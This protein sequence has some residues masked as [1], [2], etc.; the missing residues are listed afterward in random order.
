[1]ADAEHLQT[2]APLCFLLPSHS[3]LFTALHS[4]KASVSIQEEQP[5]GSSLGTTPHYVGMSMSLRWLTALFLFLLVS[6]GGAA[7]VEDPEDELLNL[8]TDEDLDLHLYNTFDYD[9][10]DQEIDAPVPEVTAEPEAAEEEEEEEN[11]EEVEEEDQSHEEFP[12]PSTPISTTLDFKAK[13]LFGPNTG[14]GMPT[15]LLCVC[16]G[17]SVY[18]DD[19]DLEDIPPLPKD[20]AHFYGRFNKI[21][22]I[23]NSTFINLNN[24]QSIDLTGNDISEID[25]A[26]FRPLLLLQQLILADNDVKMLPELPNS[27]K[28]ID[29][30]NNKLKN[31][32]LHTEGFQDMSDLEYLYLSDNDLDYVP[33]P[34]P[35]SLRV[36][37]LQN[38]NIQSLHVDTFCH[39]HD[40]TFV[41]QKLEDI[42]LDGNPLNTHL[43]GA[44]YSCL[45]RLPVGSH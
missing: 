35:L 32:G 13:E 7:P 37:H 31:S 1:M 19:S 17:G 11:V 23:K 22:H 39:S 30:R 34:L 15:C 44:A 12:K 21:E 25:E 27:M 26:A 42:R 5:Q 9:D 16:L 2:Y 6:S 29:L 41:R 8:D 45:P 40:P 43:F 4:V 36:L 18:C 38:N 14:M 28:L 10:L 24:L 20:T 3:P 33:T